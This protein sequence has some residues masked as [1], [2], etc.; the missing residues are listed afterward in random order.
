MCVNAV[1]CV[2]GRCTVCHG[3]VLCGRVPWC[4]VRYGGV[5]EICAGRNFRPTP[6]PP[7][8]G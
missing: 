6:A 1:C 5:L 8:T 7:C 2:V 3:D 4:S